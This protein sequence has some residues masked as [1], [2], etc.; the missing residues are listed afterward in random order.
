MVLAIMV[1]VVFEAIAYTKTLEDAANVIEND[2]DNVVH[3][4]PGALITSPFTDVM[5]VA[6]DLY[7]HDVEHVEGGIHVC[8][9]HTV[10]VDFLA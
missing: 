9:D 10:S 8:S 5:E 6:G 7:R 2:N 4:N 3:L 1:T